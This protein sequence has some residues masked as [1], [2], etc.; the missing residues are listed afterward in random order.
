MRT[1]NIDSCAL[2]I[3]SNVLAK[4]STGQPTCAA[5]NRQIDLVSVEI[6]GKNI[7]VYLVFLLSAHVSND[8][9][10]KGRLEFMLFVLRSHV[11]FQH[12]VVILGLVLIGFLAGDSGPKS[13]MI[14]QLARPAR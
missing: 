9:P 2:N 10:R 12:V 13:S 11:W 8:A 4:A 5:I 14:V 3:V 7:C 1:D 6:C